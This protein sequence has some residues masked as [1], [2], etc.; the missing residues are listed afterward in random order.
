MKPP[1]IC[2][3]HLC[4]KVAELVLSEAK[5]DVF[6][7]ARVSHRLRLG[8]SIAPLLRRLNDDFARRRFSSKTAIQ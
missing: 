4:Q 3:N 2:D 5:D 8:K 6:G 1:S 7:R